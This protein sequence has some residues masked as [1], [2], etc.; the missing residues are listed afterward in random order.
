[1]LDGEVA[2]G[3]RLT[4]DFLLKASYRRDHWPEA[5]PP[6]FAFPDGHAVAVQ[7]SYFLDVAE[8]LARKE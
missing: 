5:D 8:L 7:A 2:L 6:G 4:R 1:V 3:Y